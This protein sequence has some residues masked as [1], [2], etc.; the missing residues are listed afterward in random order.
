MYRWDGVGPPERW[1]AANGGWVPVSLSWWLDRV[2][3]GDPTLDKISKST[4]EKHMT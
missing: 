4:A 3:D 2:E 1:D